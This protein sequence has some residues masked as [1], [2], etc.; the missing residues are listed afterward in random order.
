MSNFTLE[1]VIEVE[2]TASASFVLKDGQRA[3]MFA[4]NAYGTNKMPEFEAVF[5]KGIL[6]Y[7]NSTLCLDGQEIESD[8]T[9][10]GEKAYWGIGH[11]ALFRA[12]Y[13]GNEYFS[14]LDI[15]NTMYT[16]FGM[17]ESAKENGKEIVVK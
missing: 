8:K 12:F 15:T 6:K 16:L 14:P 11:K 7:E 2:D 3:V 9:V 4:T 5:E 13:E 17:Y 1:D 10:S